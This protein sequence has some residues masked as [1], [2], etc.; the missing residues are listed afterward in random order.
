MSAGIKLNPVCSF[1]DRK[2]NSTFC[3]T[4]KPSAARRF[5][6]SPTRLV[7]SSKS[8]CSVAVSLQPQEASTMEHFD[9]TVPSKGMTSFN[10]I[11]L[12]LVCNLHM[13]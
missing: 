1:R 10:F 5:F 3:L 13:M 7:R 2:Q 8:F 12:F 4:L 6:I 9:N 11:V